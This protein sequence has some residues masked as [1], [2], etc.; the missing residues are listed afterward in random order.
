MLFGVFQ[1][2]VG[3]PG[4]WT[5]IYELE[6]HLGCEPD[7]LVPDLAGWRAGRLVDRDDEDEP[8]ITVIPD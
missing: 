4:G 3:G 7:I 8:F 2:G 1:V 6:L 5:I